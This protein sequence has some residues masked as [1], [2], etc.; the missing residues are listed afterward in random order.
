MPDQQAAHDRLKNDI[1][2]ALGQRPDILI[3]NNPTGVFRSFYRQAKIRVGVPGRPDITGTWS[4]PIDKSPS[5]RYVGLAFAIEVKTGSGRLGPQ[6]RRWRDR[7]EALGGHYVLARSVED[8]VN[9]FPQGGPAWT[10][11]RS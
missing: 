6:Q 10:T 4:V 11:E 9:A 3:E 7:F 2:I 8:A 1:L 5:A